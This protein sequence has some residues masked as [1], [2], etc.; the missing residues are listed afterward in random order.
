MLAFTGFADFVYKITGS[1]NS[2]VA[3]TAPSSDTT[4]RKVSDKPI[5]IVWQKIQTDFTHQYAIT[6]FVLP[7]SQ[8]GA[9]LLRGNPDNSILYKSDFRYFDQYTAEEIEGAY[10][11]GRYKDASTLSDNIRRMNYDIHTGAYFGL[12][13]RIALFLIA[14]IVATLPVTGFLFWYGRKYK[15]KKEMRFGR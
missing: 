4:I 7:A 14:I 12:P 9:I 8:T 13:G 6:M 1:A 3:K 15:H 11:W 5:D 10:V 2:V